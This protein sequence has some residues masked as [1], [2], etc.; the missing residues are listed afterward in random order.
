MLSGGSGE[1]DQLLTAAVTD[2]QALYLV[3]AEA[4][5]L[6]SPRPVV[7]VAGT[8]LALLSSTSVTPEAAAKPDQVE[9]RIDAARQAANPDVKARLW[10]EALAIAPSDERVRIGALRA[11]LALRRD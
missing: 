3:R 7:G 4:A 8:E 11:A 10:Q 6:A 1:R 9:A 5:R 2:T